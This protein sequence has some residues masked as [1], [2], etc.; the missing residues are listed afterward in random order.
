MKRG[1]VKGGYVGFLSLV[2]GGALLY[3]LPLPWIIFGLQQR[4][5]F[6]VQQ[7]TGHWWSGELRG[8]HWQGRP[9][10][11]VR[12]RWQ[13]MALGQGALAFTLWV[14]AA[15]DRLQLTLGRRG[16][17]WYGVIDDGRL[18]WT[19]IQ[20]WSQQ[21]LPL[22]G[23]LQVTGQFRFPSDGP[24]VLRWP[25]D[26]DLQITLT[27][28]VL[29]MNAPL[30]LGTLEL[31]AQRTSDDLTMRVWDTGGPL[32]IAG[33]LTLDP[34]HRYR[35]EGQLRSRDSA[36]TQLNQ[37]LSLIGVPQATGHRTFAF[38]GKLP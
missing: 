16:H 18:S 29:T 36:S 14:N 1:W 21:S 27:P 9:L 33:R 3:H 4:I 28:L 26:L 13:P 5:P 31:Q 7:V 17:E 8:V 20:M 30:D 37:W 19:T 10:E 24:K 32:E 25:T 22:S 11:T 2:T 35:G 6:T 12:W 15:N 34:G 23:N 38:Q